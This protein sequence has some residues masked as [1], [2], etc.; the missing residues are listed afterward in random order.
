MRPFFTFREKSIN[1]KKKKINKFEFWRSNEDKQQETDLDE[2]GSKKVQDEKRWSFFLKTIDHRMLP[3]VR[4]LFE[5]RLWSSRFSSVSLRSIVESTVIVV[6]WVI[7][8][9]IVYTRLYLYSYCEMPV[10]QVVPT[11]R[12]Y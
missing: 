6:E 10:V 1:E 9:C 11:V 7:Y 8:L 4:N 2:T 12:F 3:A 5:E